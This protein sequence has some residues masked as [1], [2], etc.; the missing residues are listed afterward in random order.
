M[1]IAAA[2]LALLAG[3]SPTDSTVPPYAAQ[4][5]LEQLNALRATEGQAALVLDVQLDTF[6]TAA[7]MDFQMTGNAHAYFNNAGQAKFT[8]GFCALATE[9]QAPAWPT[10]TVNEAIDEILMQMWSEG[11]GGAHHDAL[12]TPNATRLGVGLVLVDAQLWF[13]NDLSGVCP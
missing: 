10:G 11:P 8:Q 2:L 1:K 6:A 13:T 9:V 12:A 4:H 5:N 3:C 7:S